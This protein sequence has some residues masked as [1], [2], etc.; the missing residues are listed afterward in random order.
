[1]RTLTRRTAMGSC[2]AACALAVSWPGPVVARD[3]CR[4]GLSAGSP[5]VEL[6][7]VFCGEIN[8]RGQAVGF[9]S[10][11]GG[12]NPPTV[13]DTG[14]PRPVPG[15]PGLYNLTQF[16]I[17]QDGQ[18]GIKGISTFFPDKCSAGDVVAAIQFAFSNGHRKEEQFRGMS[19]PGCTTADGRQ[20]P[21]TGFT[22]GR[23]GSHV[24]TGYPDV[25]GG[26]R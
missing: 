2:A 25:G 23:E 20:F 22:G 15:Y 7:H 11:P 4:D 17:A 13:R 8:R 9:H 10:R 24:R 19:G 21:I 12:V 18:T 26:R 16:Q 1:M 14:T 5:R 3:S 6:R